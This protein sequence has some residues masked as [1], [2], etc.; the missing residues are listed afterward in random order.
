MNNDEII[1]ALWS[2]DEFSEFDDDSDAD[3]DFTL[4]IIA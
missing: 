3:L 1:P 4:V 2:S